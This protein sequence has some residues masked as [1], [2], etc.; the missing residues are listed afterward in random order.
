MHRPWRCAR[1]NLPMNCCPRSSA[2]YQKRARGRTCA[3]AVDPAAC[4]LIVRRRR[5]RRELQADFDFGII[6]GQ[7]NATTQEPN[8]GGVGLWKKGHRVKLGIASAKLAFAS[9]K[10]CGPRGIDP[11]SEPDRSPNGTPILAA[12]AIFIDHQNGRTVVHGR[13]NPDRLLLAGK[14]SAK[15]RETGYAALLGFL[16]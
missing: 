7:A 5:V 14:P 15:M 10:A 13:G 16:G 3:A 2:V 1:I 11:M 4:R 12:Y 6:G 9:P 8:I